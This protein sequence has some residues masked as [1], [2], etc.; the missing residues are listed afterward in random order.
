MPWAEGDPTLAID[1]SGPAEGV[2]AKSSW[3]GNEMGVGFSEVVES[4]PN[5]VVKTKLE[6]TKPFEM[7]QLAEVSLTPTEGGTRVNWSVSGHSNFFFRLISVF[8]NCDAMIGGEFEKG[9]SKL[10]TIAETK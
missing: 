10:K 9:L 4:V 3:T 1:Y 8:V 7:S 6:Y 2:G 5:Q